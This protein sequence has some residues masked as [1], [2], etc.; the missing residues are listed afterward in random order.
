VRDLYIY[1][2]VIIFYKTIIAKGIKCSK[3]MFFIKKLIFCIINVNLQL[4]DF[5]FVGS[6]IPQIW[7]ITY[8]L[9][10]NIEAILLL[11]SSQ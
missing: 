8:L 1:E 3:A 4:Q 5:E 9:N 7:Y 6:N 2:S 11:S 10:L